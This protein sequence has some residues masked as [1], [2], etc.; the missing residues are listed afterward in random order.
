MCLATSY[1]TLHQLSRSRSKI[2]TAV[3]ARSL[4]CCQNTDKTKCSLVIT[5]NISASQLDS[6]TTV[7]SNSTKN[8]FSMQTLPGL[9]KGF[10][11]AN[12]HVT[13][14]S[15]FDPLPTKYTYVYCFIYLYGSRD[16]V[17]GTGTRLRIRSSEV[18]IPVGASYLS[19]LL[20]VHTGS[21]ARP[22][23]CS[24]GT[25][26]PFPEINRSVCEVEHLP[27]PSAD[28]KNEWS[29]TSTPPHAFTAWRGMTS[30]YRTQHFFYCTVHTCS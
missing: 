28:A 8:L 26:G 13:R 27:P 12:P 17:I 1:R 10:R 24:M 5:M 11:S 29:Y 16:C 6:N 30:L 2:F 9:R 7:H 20:N 3:H 4:C 25:G 18:R 22:A 19:F 23:S 15:E 14:M 21:G